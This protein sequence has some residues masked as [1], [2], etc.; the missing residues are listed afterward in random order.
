MVTTRTTSIYV[1]YDHVFHGD[2]QNIL[3]GIL[4]KAAGNEDNVPFSSSSFSC[5][6]ILCDH[7]C[8]A[9]SD[10]DF[11]KGMLE[12]LHTVQMQVVALRVHRND[13]V[14]HIQGR[15][16][17]EMDMLQVYTHDQGMLEDNWEHSLEK[18]TR[19]GDT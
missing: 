9:Y 3:H 8:A 16:I 4:R 1:S 13:V 15:H 12:K 19:A 17:H 6:C 18:G 11:H 2:H 7:P 5:A 10:H 14:A